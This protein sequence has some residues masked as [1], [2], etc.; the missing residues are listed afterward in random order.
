[1][2]RVI[3]LTTVLGALL[4]VLTAILVLY[5]MPP[6]DDFHPENPYWNG[7]SKL[8]TLIQ[9]KPIKNIKRLHKYDP[10]EVALMI[11]GPS[12]HFNMP[13]IKQI[14]TFLLEGGLMILADDFGTANDVLKGLNLTLRLSGLPLADSFQGEKISYMPRA[15]IHLNDLDEI[16]LNYATII[17]VT[18][19]SSKDLYRL[20]FS[21]PLSFLDSDL[22]KFKDPEERRGP[23]TVAIKISYGNG[24]LILIS[25]SSLFINSMINMGDNLRF[26]RHLLSDRLVLLDTS[27]WEIS[28]ITMIKRQLSKSLEVLQT[29]EVKYLL[30]VIFII[31]LLRLRKT[32]LE[33][34]NNRVE[35]LLERHP[36]WNK[37]ILEILEEDI[38]E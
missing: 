2:R 8:T 24:T 36:T 15:K 25:D 18:E 37:K 34:S 17:E 22:D 19:K 4:G 5:L 26:L 35:R 38:H 20:A 28:T 3:S 12:K 33:K 9:I 23:F 31:S 21:T 10:Q 30:L 6:T 7:L 16:I 14:K 32:S 1:M 29:P 11:V 13:E 27:H